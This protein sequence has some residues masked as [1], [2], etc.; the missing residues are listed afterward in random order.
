M[1]A[2]Q[3]DD[4]SARSGDVV[5]VGTDTGMYVVDFALNGDA[6]GNNGFNLGKINRA[7]NLFAV[8]DANGRAVYDGTCGPVNV[9]THLGNFC[10]STTNL[11]P[12]LLAG[13]TV[14]RAGTLPVVRPNGSGAG[15]G[16]LISNSAGAAAPGYHG[17]VSGAINGARSSRLPNATEESS[18]TAISACGGLHVYQIATDSLGMAVNASATDAPTA[19]L[20]AQELVAVY[21]CTTTTWNA[22]PG[23]SAGSTATIHPL[24][25]QSGS[26]TRNFFLAALQAAN[27]GTAITPGA[28]VRTV[29]E[30]DPE[31]IY[32]D[33]SPA[34]AIEPFSGGKLSMLNT[35]V[36]G[37]TTSYFGDSNAANNGSSA[38][39]AYG[40]APNTV[41]F[42]ATSGTAGDT[43]PVYFDAA[44]GIYVVLRQTDVAS[45]TL[46]AFEPG[47]TLNWVQTLVT[48][49][50]VI[51]G[52]FARTSNAPLFA[53]AGMT[54]A[55][56]D[57][58]INPTTC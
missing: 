44:R 55:F 40:F 52:W 13:T 58:G 51:A 47:S 32:T 37:L 1:P 53:S 18:C 54:Q 46:P 24:L 10:D 5:F 35:N 45:T 26:G 7:V 39:A 17:L 16:A 20:S 57:C 36:S 43:N 23:N 31:G 19:G 22:L 48:G 3:A 21:Q 28:C 4:A 49:N 8:G 15:I 34:D 30:H 41:K 11:T 50:G 12:N 25:P 56:L 27:G 29:Q 6:A 2:A 42:L 38:Q 9:T 33:P 14:I